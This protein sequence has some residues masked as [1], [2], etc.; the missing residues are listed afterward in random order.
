M[1]KYYICFFVSLFY[2]QTFAIV[3]IRHSNTKESEWS[4]YLQSHP[5]Y[6]PFS[7]YYRSINSSLTDSQLILL[8]QLK[9]VRIQKDNISEN[10]IRLELLKS[11]DSTIWN[12]SVRQLFINIWPTDE[13][14]QIRLF[15]NSESLTSKTVGDKLNLAINTKLITE[16][17]NVSG[18]LYVNGWA[19]SESDLSQLQFFSNRYYQIVILSDSYT[20]QIFTGYARDFKFAESQP[21]VSGDCYSPK[22]NPQLSWKSALAIFPNHCTVPFLGIQTPTSSE[23][24]NTTLDNPFGGRKINDDETHQST[25]SAVPKWIWYTAGFIAAGCLIN[26]LSKQYQIDISL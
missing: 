25:F 11:L 23:I 26:S 10:E 19:I 8:D 15:S 3:I 17:H 22:W 12:E 16:L 1:I 4:Q 5:D 20:P 9:A 13:I 24:E 18:S 7:L 14:E 6:I 2:F 21:I